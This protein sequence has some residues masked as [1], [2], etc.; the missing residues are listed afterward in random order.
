MLCGPDLP[1]GA[2]DIA[3]VSFGPDGKEGTHDDIPSW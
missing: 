3:I 2:K 1:S